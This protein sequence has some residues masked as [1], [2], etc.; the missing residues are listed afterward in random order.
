MNSGAFIDTGLGYKSFSPI[1][2]MEVEKRL[3]LKELQSYIEKANIS[4]GELRALESLLPNPELLTQR[5]AI[6]EALLS[7]MIEGT[8][9][10]LVEIFENKDNASISDNIREVR[11]YFKALNHGTDS[12][13]TGK[14]PLSLRLL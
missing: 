3:N 14:L 9:S 8:Q 2:L 7:S 1:S 10:T 13:K 5:Y 4:I 6:K 12:I 11:N